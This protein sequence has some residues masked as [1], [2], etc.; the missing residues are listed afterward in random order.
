[1]RKEPYLCVLH[2]PPCT[3]KQARTA[4]RSSG[5]RYLRKIIACRSQNCASHVRPNS[6]ADMAASPHYI[7]FDLALPAIS[8]AGLL[9]PVPAKE[10][11]KRTLPSPYLKF[12]AM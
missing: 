8:I 7:L 3:C 11:D 4:R 10:F 2:I 6:S 5:A 1:M 12:S 9:L